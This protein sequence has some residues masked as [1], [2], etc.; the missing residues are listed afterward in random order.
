M[1]ELHIRNLPP[2]LHGKLR[3]R[4]ADEGRSMSAEVVAI[5]RLVLEPD[6]EARRRGGAV[7][8]LREIQARHRLAPGSKP[9]EVL[10]REDRD[11]R[12]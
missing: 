10:I 6:E 8:S 2:A 12:G 1:P 4:A 5:L 9:A 11:A 7:A 3:A